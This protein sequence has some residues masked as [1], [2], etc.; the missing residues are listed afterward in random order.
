MSVE[1][2]ALQ[3]RLTRAACER[4]PI[5]LDEDPDRVA[6]GHLAEPVT[7]EPDEVIANEGDPVIVKGCAARQRTY[8]T[9]GW[10]FDRDTHAQLLN[11]GGAYVLL[12]YSPGAG[13][14]EIEDVDEIEI[15]R[16]TLVSAE[17]IE[18]E[19]RGDWRNGVQQTDHARLS[20]RAMFWGLEHPGDD[21]L[22]HLGRGAP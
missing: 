15:R 4:F 13:S 3:E 16:M 18:F 8:P 6:H 11:D 10:V 17:R 19:I 2:R 22:E 20:W 14:D 7:V 5:E 1:E 21:E 12:V 9:G